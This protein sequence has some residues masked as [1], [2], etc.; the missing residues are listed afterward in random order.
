MEVAVFANRDWCHLASLKTVLRWNGS[1]QPLP[2]F[3][4]RTIFLVSSGSPLFLPCPS[5][6]NRLGFACR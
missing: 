2:L 1:A 5:S 6:A 4:L 3:V